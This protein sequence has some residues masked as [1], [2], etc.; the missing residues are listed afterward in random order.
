MSA[1]GVRSRVSR[2]LASAAAVALMYACA[3]APPASAAF[4]DPCGL[5]TQAELSTAFGLADVV[6]HNTVVGAPGNP[7]GVV[8]NRCEAF[9]WRG[10]KPTN[11]KRKR[12]SLL[13]GTMARLTMQSWVP[14]EGPQA[15]A[16]RTTRFDETLKRLRGAAS[17]RFLKGL[18]G[19]RSVPPRFG[20]DSRVAFSATAGG[21]R[22]VRAFWW[23][24]EAKSL[25]VF[26]AVEAKGQPTLAS[27]KRVASIVVSEFFRQPQPTG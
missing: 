5:I 23:S 1:A 10:P 2:V 26:D 11:E 3:L 20:A 8:R 13:A 9:A 17:E 15:Q 24:R 16:W 14:D 21:T 12:E 4:L 22:K 27:L 18:H 6:K 25:L 7:A 19:A